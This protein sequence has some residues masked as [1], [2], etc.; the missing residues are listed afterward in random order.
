MIINSSLMIGTTQRS[1]LDVLSGHLN[2]S[3][4]I[5]IGDVMTRTKNDMD[6]LSLDNAKIWDNEE[7]YPTLDGYNNKVIQ[8]HYDIEF[9][10][11]TFCS[12]LLILM[13]KS[14]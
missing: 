6:L 2:K 4:Y 5:I 10:K 12:G 13:K 14:N 9:L 7:F 8:Q 1:L 11:V 3:G